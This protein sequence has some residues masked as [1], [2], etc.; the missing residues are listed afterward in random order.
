MPLMDMCQGSTNRGLP[1]LACRSGGFALPWPSLAVLS[2]PLSLCDSHSTR[3]ARQVLTLRSFLRELG[4]LHSA[5]TTTLLPC[6]LF[7]FNHDVF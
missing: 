5:S 6:H 3:A 7:G 2:V 1:L 4:P